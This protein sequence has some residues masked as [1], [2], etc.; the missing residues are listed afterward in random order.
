MTIALT[1]T[2]KEGRRVAC[3]RRGS[4]Q[5]QL[6]NKCDAMKICS[7]K[8]S[9]RERDYRQSPARKRR[10]TRRLAT[11]S[12]VA[13]DKYGLPMNATVDAENNLMAE[14]TGFDFKWKM[15]LI[16]HMSIP[17]TAASLLDISA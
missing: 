14:Q 6:C 11:I 8:A 15:V 4:V 17:S 10:P 7:I 1:I 3:D 2:K 12:G 9:E 5:S 13:N 16:L